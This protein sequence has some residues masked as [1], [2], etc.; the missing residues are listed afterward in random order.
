MPSRLAPLL[1]ARQ[2]PLDDVKTTFSSWDSCMSKTYCKWPVIVGIIIGGLILFSVIACIARCIC[3]G[4]ELACCCFKCCTCCCPSGGSRGHKRVKSDPA[5]PYPQP[6]GA[7]PPNPYAQNPYAQAHAAAPPAPPID[8]RP[9]NQQ[10]RSNAMPTF[11]PAAKPERP[12]F[13]TF[14]S[15]KAVVNED[16]LPAM[17]T[18]KDGR[19]VHIEVE[20]QPVP[21]KRGDLEMDRLDRNGS[22]ASGSVAATATAAAA[23]PGTR[24]SPGPGRSPVSAVDN[25]GYPSGRDNDSFGGETAPLTSQG[26]YNQS[27]AQ[28][29]GYGRRSPPQNTSPVQDGGG[30]AGGYAQQQRQQPYGRQPQAYD[31]R[32]QLNQYNQPSSQQYNQQSPQQYNQQSPQQYNQQNSQQYNQQNS[33]QYN[34]QASQY[35]QQTSQYNQ[36]GSYQQAGSYNQRDYYDSPDR[37]QSPAPPP[38][39]PYGYNDSNNSP[40]PSYD[41]FAPAPAQQSVPQSLA[42]GYVAT[43]PAKPT[44]PPVPA[45]PGQRA[46]TPVSG[47]IGQQQPY[48]AFSPGAQ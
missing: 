13:A 40:A 3:C 17:P 4:A 22:V 37:Y 45:Y 1:L 30:Y 48:R 27:Y 12:Q 41:N 32:D 21:E 39:N 11:A 2:N 20:E 5:A 19:D 31:S 43:E 35:N 8:T 28:Q 34:Q 24:R 9:V 38:S 46:Y 44:S 26:Q 23:I 18:W 16:A 15:T 36:Q 7:P 29:D 42:P 33:Q 14:D 47:S 6:Y 10:Y 25:Y